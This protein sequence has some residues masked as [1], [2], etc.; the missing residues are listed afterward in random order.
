MD[1]AFSRLKLVGFTSRDSSK[2]DISES[3]SRATTA[4]DEATDSDLSAEKGLVL[5]LVG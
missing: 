3:R 2:A 4:H 5:G 1:Q